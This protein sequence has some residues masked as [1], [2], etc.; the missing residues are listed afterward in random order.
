MSQDYG[1]CNEY[2]EQAYQSEGTWAT[3]GPSE[4]IWW[5]TTLFVAAAQRKQFKIKKVSTQL[6]LFI[7]RRTSS[8]EDIF[9]DTENLLKK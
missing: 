5:P 9:Y 4:F 1:M 7:R 3:C 2:A 8:G 6:A